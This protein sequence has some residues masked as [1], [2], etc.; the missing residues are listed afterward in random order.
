MAK[1]ASRREATKSAATIGPTP[2]RLSEATVASPM[3]PDPM[4]SGT[5]FAV[6]SARF[7]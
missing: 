7:T 2:S 6:T 1:A 5:S 4:T 3:A